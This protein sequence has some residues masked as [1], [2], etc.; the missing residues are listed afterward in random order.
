MISYTRIKDK[1][2]ASSNLFVVSQNLLF[3]FY[4]KSW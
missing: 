2:S 4:L 1:I 3:L